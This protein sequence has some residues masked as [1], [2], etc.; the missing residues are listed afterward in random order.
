M[1]DAAAVLE[2]PSLETQVPE[3]VRPWKRAAVLAFR[4]FAVYFGIYVVVTQMFRGLIPF[5][6]PI[7]NIGAVG[8][9]RWMVEWTA[10]NVFGVTSPLVFTGSGSGDK[11]TDWVLAFC[12]L[13]IT[14][15]ITAVWS[16]A[17]RRP[18]N[19]DSAHKWFRLFLRFSLGSTM[20]GY[21]VSKVIPLQMPF[22]TLT[23]LLEPYGYFSPMGVLWASIGASRSYEIFT[24]ALE[25][26]AGILLF[27]PQTAL[28]GAL[29]A[30]ACMAEIFTLNMTYDVP[31]KLFS[32]HLLLMSFFLLAPD[33]KR[34]LNVLLFNRTA[35]VSPVPPLGS[36]TRRIRIGVALQIVFGLMLV[37]QGVNNSINAW[38]TF[39]GG[40]PRSP[41]FGIWNVTYM[42]VDGVERAPLVTDY[43]RWR[44]LAFDFP[45]RMSFHR[46]DDTFVQFNNKIDVVAKSIVLTRAGN[47]KWSST[48]SFDR[49]APD[50]M[51]LQGEMDGKKIQMRLELFPRENFLLVTRG[52]NWVQE[53]PFNR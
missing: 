23:R 42:S 9:V 4:F 43:D 34:L 17:A 2:F 47:D 50:R 19:Y 36:T 22:P 30:M 13:I 39:G 41:L 20:L 27:I 53:Y 32:S 6:V 15:A 40:S 14:T 52:F 29:L 12:L 33:T 7:P 35:E 10:V 1:A 5:T 3:P 28:L 46:M 45:T 16:I 51:T 24:G 8:P 48:F 21:G 26:T 11:T 44:R 31:V 25:M 38:S 18:V 49:P 37:G